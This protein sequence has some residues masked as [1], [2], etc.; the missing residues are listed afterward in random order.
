MTARTTRIAVAAA[1][2]C[3]VASASAD[4]WFV[5]CSRPA[6]SGNGRS[7]ATAFHSIQEAVNAAAD[8]DTVTVF[9]GEYSDGGHV[10]ENGYTNRV[11]I[12]GKRLTLRSRGGRDMTAI[13]GAH[14][15][16]GSH[17]DGD[18][19]RTLYSDLGPA[20]VRC[21]FAENAGGTRIEGFTIRDGATHEC[22][23]S[24]DMAG[25]GGGILVAG[26]DGDW[27]NVQV[28]DCAI[29]NCA[30][31]RGGGM[32]QGVAIRCLFEYNRTHYGTGHAARQANLYNCLVRRNSRDAGANVLLWG[33]NLANCTVAQNVRGVVFQNCSLVNTLAFLNVYALGSD[34]SNTGTNC[35]FGTEW[36]SY[37]TSDSVNISQTSDF[38]FL[39]P[40]TGDF[41][42]AAGCTAATLGTSEA[43]VSLF[44]VP[45]SDRYRDF[46]GAAIPTS[47]TI[48]AGCIQGTVVPATGAWLFGSRA[49]ID[50]YATETANN[51]AR[52]AEAPKFFRLAMDLDA[53]Q[54]PFTFASTDRGLSFPLDDGT[55][56]IMAPPVSEGV[57]SYSFQYATNVLYVAKTGND[58]KDGRTPQ[59]AFKTIQRAI[60]A[61]P[62]LSKIS[63]D[64]LEVRTIIH[65]GPGEYTA[66]DGTT[67]NDGGGVEQAG[68]LSV[69]LK[70][71]LVVGSG[72]DSC[73]IRG[74]ADSGVTADASPFGC[75]DN[76]VRCLAVK[77]SIAC[78]RKFTFADGHGKLYSGSQ[79]GGAIY[80]GGKSYTYICDSVITNCVGNRGAISAARLE[81]CRIVDC[82]DY[83]CTIRSA[84]AQNCVFEATDASFAPKDG[85]IGQDAAAYGCT[86]ASRYDGQASMANS[87]AATIFNSIVSQGKNSSASH[88]ASGNVYWGMSSYAGTGYL[89]ADPV[90]ADETIGDYR[91]LACS[92]AIGQGTA[93]ETYWKFAGADLDGNMPLIKDGRLTPGAVQ[94]TVAAV[95]VA[96]P[97]DGY[98]T[99]VGTNAVEEGETITVDF[100]A[101]KR[102]MIG[103]LVD[104]VTNDASLTTFSYTANGVLPME[105]VNVAAI[106]NPH[107]YVS[108][109]GN[110]SND[111]WSPDTAKG[112]LVGAMADAIAGDTVHAAAGVYTNKSTVQETACISWPDPNWKLRARVVVPEGVT[113]VADEGPE[114]TFIIGEKDTTE[115]AI[116][117]RDGCGTNAMRCVVLNSHAV[118]RGFTVCGGRVYGDS[119]SENDNNNAGG[120]L[121]RNAGNSDFSPTVEDCIISNNW[122]R[123]GAG[124]YRGR[125]VGCRILEN[126][127]YSGDPAG[128]YSSLYSCYVDRNYGS[129][130]YS[131]YYAVE[132]C[133]FGPDNLALNGTR[134]TGLYVLQQPLSSAVAKNCLFLD[135]VRRNDSYAVVATNSVF[136]NDDDSYSPIEQQRLGCRLMSVA[137]VK[138]VEGSCVPSRI[139]PLVDMAD[140]TLMSER[141]KR[142]DATGGQ[143]TYNGTADIGAFEYDWRPDYAAYLGGSRARVDEASENVVM[144]SGRTSLTMGVGRLMLTL[145]GG[146]TDGNTKYTVPFEVTGAGT[147]SIAANGAPAVGYTAAGA[148]SLQLSSALAE[149]VFA[150][151]YDSD[152]SGVQ[153]GIIRRRKAGFM[154]SFK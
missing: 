125:Y 71:I 80:G 24:L 54:Y 139:S 2:M 149:N 137:D 29:I 14:D 95:I 16:V 151:N 122:G 19:S 85:F 83:Y 132:N 141:A 65:V 49:I 152:D 147:L 26:S 94:R 46:N 5:D 4:E 21:V 110:D 7:A 102:P 61:A 3:T 33:C 8:G 97:S 82:R 79:W 63:D 87:G 52:G 130:T 9:P 53:G 148:A 133:T 56:V 70:R 115:F 40:A 124:A 117:N 66:E 67:A 11:A 41:R 81:R 140:G 20:A 12:I 76:A 146:S 57:K 88:I 47:G 154:V 15:P 39:S 1:I 138:L 77:D 153:F 121:C 105:P 55:T 36:S 30:S 96:N 98:L 64:A 73:I 44:A 69:S 134:S 84:V 27:R 107:W 118:L 127:G 89:K 35:L 18:P 100:T 38:Q 128:R 17:I 108:P 136:R 86:L 135:R 129:P 91:L 32:Y 13:V 103:F 123:S 68:V 145:T 34:A 25:I 59:T 113:L 45:E 60:D 10:D 120:I 22:P 114:K 28:A 23:S 104:G 131:I 92:G 58:S 144:D 143:R 126:H 116:A 150:F 6:G 72:A 106:I 42:L 90:F 50:G 78:F 101:G 109:Y 51:W 31:T 74:S 99:N 119:S 112:T 48:A 93:D 37:F 75:G 62:T 142:M 111:G 43:M